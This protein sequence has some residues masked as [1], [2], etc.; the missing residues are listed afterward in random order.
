MTDDEIIGDMA[1]SMYEA[2]P[3]YIA[4]EDAPWIE[5]AGKKDYLRMA[6]AALAVAK[7]R[8]SAAAT[9]KECGN[10]YDPGHPDSHPN[11]EVCPRCGTI[12]LRETAWVV[13]NDCNGVFDVFMDKANAQTELDVHPQYNEADCYI[14]PVKLMRMNDVEKFY[15]EMKESDRVKSRGNAA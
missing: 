6:A 1:Q 7:S 3:D 9:C 4:G 13:R 12:L 5:Y 11:I 10:S 15:E 8:M 14:E 2:E